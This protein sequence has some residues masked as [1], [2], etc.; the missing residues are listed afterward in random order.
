MLHL[1]RR[2]SCADSEVEVWLIALE[3]TAVHLQ[4]CSMLLSCDEQL[5]A[6][7]FQFARDR[8]RYIAGRAMLRVVL[9]RQLGESPEH[10]SIESGPHGKPV[11]ADRTAPVHFN[12]AHT[13]DLAIL[14]ISSTQV[15][16][17]DIESLERT[18]DHDALAQRFFSARENAEF[19][20]ISPATRNQAFLARWTCKEAV[21]K[22]A[23]KGLRMPLNQIEVS[24]APHGQPRLLSLPDGDARQWTLHS[25][26]AGSNYVAALALLRSS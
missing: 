2:V 8:N 13:G 6:D 4:Q 18:V 24:V 12:L 3:A 22:A 10:I 11:L 7:R 14:A 1:A 21:A 23:G 26:D 9:A 20:R 15:P 17:V 25:I 5:R 19:E 16:G